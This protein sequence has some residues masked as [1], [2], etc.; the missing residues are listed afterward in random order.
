VRARE[1][2]APAASAGKGKLLRKR[3]CVGEK[4]GEKGKMLSHRE[5]QFSSS[6]VISSE[7][8][9]KRK[10]SLWRKE[11]AREEKGERPPHKKVGP[12]G[13]FTEGGEGTRFG[14]GGGE[15]AMK[16]RAQPKKKKVHKSL[17]EKKGKKT[18]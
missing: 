4:G 6:A 7:K 8:K 16:E 14:G 5:K 12:W 2:R 10:C 9:G 13:G 11:N 17:F 3:K 18:L 15:G 1:C